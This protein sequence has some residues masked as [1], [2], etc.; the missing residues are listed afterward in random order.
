M[1]NY[2]YKPI[3][4]NTRYVSRV[5]R[6]GYKYLFLCIFCHTDGYCRR[7]MFIMKRLLLIIAAMLPLTGLRAQ[8]N[9]DQVMR[10]GCN[11]LYF[12]DYVL[13]IQ[14]FNQV[15][16][17]KPYL[18]QPYFYRA[19]AKLNLDDYRGAEADAST[20]IEY[21]PFI[22][23]AYEVRGVARQNQGK[24]REA[25]ADYEE[26]LS[27]LPENRQIM[28]NKAL[29]EEEIKEYDASL[30]SFDKLLKAHPNFGNG[31]VGRA[32]TLLAMG[33]T[34]RAKADLDKALSIN[35]NITNA[36]LI[37]ADIAINANGDYTAA[38]ADMDE[39]IKLQP[40]YAGFFINRAFLRYKLDDYFG[41]MAD[42]DYAIELDPLS[43]VAYFNRGLLRSEVHDVNNA[44]DDFTKVLELSPDDCR[45]LYNR[46]I[47][48]NEIREYKKA[49][50]D[51]NRVIDT[52]PDFA[53]AYYLRSEIYHANGDLRKAEADYK[54]STALARTPVPVVDQ[55]ADMAAAAGTASGGG[56]SNADEAEPTETQDEVAAR[57]TSLLT[58]Q[59]DTELEQEFNNSSIR[60]KVQDRNITVEAE[61][62]FTLSYYTSPTEL[63]ESGYFIKEVDDLNATRLLRFLIMVTNHEP[64]LS[65]EAGI[66]KHFE[67]IEYY[68]SLLANRTAR[69]VDYFGRAMD[70]MTIR[71]YKAAIADLDKAVA[72]T[73]DFTLG[74]LLRGI[75]RYRQMEVDR[76]NVVPDPSANDLRMAADNAKVS[77]TEIVADFDK[78]LDLSPRMAIAYFNKGNLYLSVNDYTS[79]LSAYNRAIELK[80]D[81]GEAYY[82]RG[83]VYFRLGNKDAGAADLSKAGELGILPSYNLLKRMSR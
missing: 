56:T 7:C 36:Y 4:K 17:A 58:I 33:D 2:G 79:A 44:I 81:F 46:A 14:Y 23:D 76:A 71:N 51:L 77:M 64:Q 26:A 3:N 8:V 27:M 21:N 55:K 39:A 9:T 70:F 63:K 60:G 43:G 45:A 19:I 59:N 49:L 18:A 1:L 24:T 72:L 82:N 5:L 48:Y 11:V 6:F 42:Y 69:A 38:L 75:A 22:T 25:I 83:Y 52:Y 28:F 57:F 50:A 15:I 31:Y 47:L 74:Y 37:R 80:P 20:A 53:G 67:S 73:P 29:A 65:D 54:R 68:N 66:K 13:S 41:A 16:Q 10:I 34:V 12:E 61:P 78:V 62:M 40:K 32:K 30:A 35:K